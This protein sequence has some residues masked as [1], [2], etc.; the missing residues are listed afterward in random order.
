MKQTTQKIISRAYKPK[1][2]IIGIGGGGSSIVNEMAQMIEKEKVFSP[3]KTNF[4]AANVDLQAIKLL[5]Y[6]QINYPNYIL[7]HL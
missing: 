7:L 5:K 1:I 4:I 3:Q 6:I 2:K